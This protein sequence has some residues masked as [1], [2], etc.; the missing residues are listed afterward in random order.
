MT[1][2]IHGSSED[3][4]SQNSYGP[5]ESAC[6]FAKTR[7]AAEWRGEPVLLV[8]SSD[9]SG[10]RSS[11]GNTNPVVSSVVFATFLFPTGNGAVRFKAHR[12]LSLP[13]CKAIPICSSRED[14]TVFFVR[15]FALFYDDLGGVE[16][17]ASFTHSKY[18]D[19]SPCLCVAEA[20]LP[21]VRMVFL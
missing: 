12:S 1:N 3:G 17:V 16:T 11:G 10:W 20:A 13:R 6:F 8:L 19:T 5:H 9:D 21:R 15:K 4:D 18:S 7:N 2:A 14:M